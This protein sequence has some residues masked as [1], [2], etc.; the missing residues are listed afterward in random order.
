MSII[1]RFINRFM[2][3]E[4][5]KDP[6]FVSAIREIQCEIGQILTPF[7]IQEQ[8][9]ITGSLIASLMALKTLME[10]ELN[11]PEFI[12]TAQEG[13]ALWGKDAYIQL[14]KMAKRVV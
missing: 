3:K 14:L 4:H 11:N 2:G 13:F 5:S 7:K 10:A 1:N 6:E 12:E 8:Y 9:I